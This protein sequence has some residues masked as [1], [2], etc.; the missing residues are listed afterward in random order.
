MP[1]VVR[2]HLCQ[3]LPAMFAAALAL[4]H[5]C[6][7]D[8]GIALVEAGHANARGVPALL[9]DLGHAHA[10]DVACRREHEDLTTRIDSECCNNRAAGTDACP[11][12]LSPIASQVF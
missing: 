11:S 5:G 2:R 7:G 9:R 3:F 6:H 12:F 8:N 1:A 10:H 4:E